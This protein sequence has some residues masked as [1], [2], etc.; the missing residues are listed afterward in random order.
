MYML[1]MNESFGLLAWFLEGFEARKI[2]MESD[3][4]I[5]LGAFDFKNKD[6]YINIL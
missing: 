5:S 3:S 6:Y 2:T 4:K 1:G